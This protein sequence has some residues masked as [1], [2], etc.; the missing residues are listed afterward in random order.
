MAYLYLTK[1]YHKRVKPEYKRKAEVQFEKIRKL[2]NPAASSILSRFHGT[3]LFEVNISRNLRIILQ[4]LPLEL[5]GQAYQIYCARMVLPH[6]SNEYNTFFNWHPNA[7]KW[8]I[9]NDISEAESAE[10]TQWLKAELEREQRSQQLPEL[11]EHLKRWLNISGLDLTDI[12]VYEAQEW[13][14]SIRIKSIWD[15]KETICKLLARIIQ[16]EDSDAKQI[17]PD[18]AGDYT[19]RLLS[20]DH[21]LHVLYEK[22]GNMLML[23]KIFKGEPPDASAINTV[24][25]HYLYDRSTYHNE[26][27]V[28][29]LRIRDARRAYP[30]YMLAEDGL[31]FKIQE[32]DAA[33]LALSPEEK[34]LLQT[35]T[36]PLFVNGQAGSGKSTMLFYLFANICA[37]E[38]SEPRLFLTWNTHLLETAKAS[39]LGILEKHPHFSERQFNRQQIEN[40]FYPFKTFI[41]DH[42]LRPDD[43]ERFDRSRYISFSKFKQAFTGSDNTSLPICRLPVR[44]KYSAEE[45]WHVVRTYIKG[46]EPDRYLVP[47]SYRQLPRKDKSVSDDRYQQIFDTIWSNWYQSFWSRNGFWDDQDLIRHVLTHPPDDFPQYP[48]IFCDEAQDFTRI[49]IE[50]LMRLSAFTRWNLTHHGNIPFVFAG[51]PYQTIN[52]TG[53]RWETLMAI[54]SDRFE[55]LNPQGLRIRFEELRQNYRA[56]PAIIKFTNLIQFFRHRFLALYDLLP[57][58]AWQKIEGVSPCILLLQEEITV[59]NLKGVADKTII[60]IPTDAD[61]HSEYDYVEKDAELKQFI[62]LPSNSSMPVSNVMSA[63]AAKGLEFDR[64]IV[65]KFG[66]E[67]PAGFARIMNG[68]KLDD[69]EDIELAYFFNK[70][71]VALSRARNF[72]FIL[73]TRKGYEKFWKYFIRIDHLA[74]EWQPAYQWQA[75]DV[76]PLVKGTLAD[77][78]NIREEN[79]LNVAREL[80]T[81]GEMQED[82]IQMQ[83]AWQYYTLINMPDKAKYCLARSYWYREDWQNAGQEFADMGNHT[84]AM[85]AFWRGQHWPELNKLFCR[86][87]DH[88]LQAC[89]ARY[90]TDQDKLDMLLQRKSD[91]I[92]ACDPLDSTWQAIVEKIQKDLSASERLTGVDVSA[93]AVFCQHL[94]GKGFKALFDQAAGLFFQ[95]G[96][97]QQAISCWDRT[98]NVE[99]ISYY[100]AKLNLAQQPAEKIL[101]NQKLKADAAII[102]IY[103]SSGDDEGSFSDET[104]KAIFDALLRQNRF[105]TAARYDGLPFITRARRLVGSVRTRHGTPENSDKIKLIFD[106]ALDHGA[107]GI[108]FIQSNLRLFQ[109]CFSSKDALRIILQQNQWEELLNDLKRELRQALPGKF[110]ESLVE[111]VCEEIASENVAHLDYAIKQVGEI[112]LV[113][114]DYVVQYL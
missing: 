34:E 47:A 26:D 5:N 13:T 80:E 20:G 54:F 49:E 93:L 100:T 72:L 37:L 36:F 102:E 30:Y 71:Y 2:E 111:V 79:P 76:A 69:H 85:K 59:A 27:L 101:W 106:M 107:E 31:W 18:Q 55:K 7:T 35:A 44:K 109:D 75:S 25:H 4:E 89:I 56:K 42:L 61:E 87:A 60:L 90:M 16:G 11:P 8:L 19:F 41:L 64:V 88:S 22:I 6:G 86:I 63:S 52:P 66:L 12:S 50:L 78:D 17:F 112:S 40:Y 94:A 43:S 57:Q 96:G 97:Y 10:I 114:T 65:Y 39:V 67:A 95:G 81:H 48:V 51:D 99:H 1:D 14:E 33:N 32:D 104:H 53:F 70:L 113:L 38:H 58:A 98:G 46:A 110:I 9:N 24:L 92:D 82:H 84:N 29:T 3:P 91:L 15:F 45:V 62:Q 68:E 23:Y 105:E 21:Q 74:E 73:D 77:I 83:R 28:Q 103:E 108:G